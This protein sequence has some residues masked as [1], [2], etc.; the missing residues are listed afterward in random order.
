ME[1]EATPSID[2]S[3]IIDPEAIERE[4]NGRIKAATVR[5]YISQRE[6]NGLKVHTVRIGRKLLLSRRGFAQWLATRIGV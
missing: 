3:D 2:L 4:S 6:L 1:T 5:Y